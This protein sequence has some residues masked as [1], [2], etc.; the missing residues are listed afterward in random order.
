MAGL[1]FPMPLVVHR[2]LLDLRIHCRRLQRELGT[3]DKR[4]IIVITVIGFITAKPRLSQTV[5]NL[6][7][8][9]LLHRR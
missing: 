5:F 8:I 3:V 1:L 4:V 2:S 7:H 6:N 9:T